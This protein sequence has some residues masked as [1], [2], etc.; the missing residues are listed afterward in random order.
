MND[1]NLKTRMLNTISSSFTRD[2]N[3]NLALL[4]ETFANQIDK[5]RNQIKNIYDWQDINQAEGKALDDIG[6]EYG[7]ARPDENDDFYRFLLNNARIKNH[8]DGSIDSVIKLVAAS[9][10]AD[11]QEFHV[12]TGYENNK[13][14]L[15]VS[16]EDIPNKYN[17]DSRKTKILL[18]NLE[19][20]IAA[21]IRLSNV[22][23]QEYV[24]GNIFVAP[25]SQSMYE[26]FNKMKLDFDLDNQNKMH[27]TFANSYKQIETVSMK[28]GNLNG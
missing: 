23:F 18:Q 7:I 2:E 24:D 17:Q 8:T 14:K 26:E 12:K 4:F 16:I 1:S 6:R 15:T 11:Y 27:I 21:G 10:Q 9:L 25:Y 22:S 5:S 3:S 13:E 19:E 20:S 28:R